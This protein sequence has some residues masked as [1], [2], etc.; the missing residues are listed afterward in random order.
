LALVHSLKMRLQVLGMLVLLFLAGCAVAFAL[1]LRNSETQVLSQSASHL[2]AVASALARDYVSRT[3]FETSK[4]ETAALQS[5]TE[6]G[7]DDVLSLMTAVVLR[8]EVDTEGGFYSVADD[9]L[10][11]YAF[12]THE[13]PGIKKDMPQKELPAILDLARKA[14]QTRQ[15]QSLIFRGERDAI[16]FEAAPVIVN[17]EV[18]GSTW[19][20]KRLPGLRSERDIRAYAGF[21]VLGAGAALC[22]LLAFLIAR[23]LSTGVSAIERRLEELEQDLETRS[24]DASELAEIARIRTGVDRL[25]ASLRQKLANERELEGKLR[26]S[27]R[28]AALGKVAAGVAHELRNPLATIRLRTQ[29][30]LRDNPEAA[31]RRNGSIVLDEIARLDQMVERLLYFA[32][33]LK[34]QR[35]HVNI[36]KILQASVETQTQIEG[37]SRSQ[38]AFGNCDETLETSA[39]PSALRQVFDNLIR[40]AIEA[41]QAA[42]GEAIVSAQRDRETA[43]IEVR[44][45]GGGIR[46]EDLPHIFDPFFTTKQAGTG[47]GLSICYEIVKGHGGDIEVHSEPGQGTTIIVSLPVVDVRPSQAPLDLGVQAQPS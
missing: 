2:S 4:S 10:L 7:A 35:Q 11:G 30:T 13:G 1:L 36:C 27:E 5:P 39:D 16:V 26:S 19:V 29:M 20:M 3:V 46:A 18:A 28:L 9:K 37:Q 47:L 38:V 45:T 17:D 32:R 25:A 24:G 33:P 23:S 41:T 12:P 42:S 15:P 40:N 44:D 34:I 22:V 43:R 21:L 6:Q 14:A 8:R 31:L